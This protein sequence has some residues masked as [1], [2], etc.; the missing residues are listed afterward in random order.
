MFDNS[1]T[2]TESKLSQHTLANT[3]T[4][5]QTQTAVQTQKITIKHQCSPQSVL[6]GGV[7]NMATGCIRLMGFPTIIKLV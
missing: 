4:F 3:L 1:S 6:T 7:K 5:Y 2:N